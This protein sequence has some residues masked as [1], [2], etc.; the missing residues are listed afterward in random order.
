MADSLGIVALIGVLLVGT[1]VVAAMSPLTAR[2]AARNLGRR[3]TRSAIVTLGLLVGTAIISSS[4]VVGDTLNYVFLE[5]AYRRLGFVD[6]TA[7]DS[8]EGTLI[9]FNE[10][11]FPLFRDGLRDRGSPVDGVAP[12]LDLVMPVRNERGN[13]GNQQ[14]TVLGLDDA[15]ESGFG[16]LVNRSGTPVRLR[17]LPPGSAVLNERASGVLNATYGH[18]LTLF[19]GTTNQTVVFAN[20][21][22]VV[23]DEGTANW[24]QRPTVLL[25][26]AAMQAAFGFSGRINLLRISNLGDVVSGVAYSERV[27]LDARLV[28]AE[29]RWRLTVATAK[30]DA[31][32]SA[33][34]IGRAASELFLVMGAF[35]VLAGILLIVNIFVMLAEERK[36]EM[37][38]SRAIGLTR[39]RLTHSFLLEG[40]AYAFAAAAIGSLAGLALGAVMIYFFDVLVPHPGVAITF[41]FDPRSVLIAFAAGI[42]LTLASIGVASARVGRLNIVR[43]IRD[44]PEPPAHTEPTRWTAT[45]I[46]FVVAGVGL[47]V[48]GA[49]V[50]TGYGLIPGLPIAAYGAAFLAAARGRARSGFTA[51]SAAVLVWILGPWRLANE[52]TDNLSALFV[53]TGAVLVLA[54]ILIAVL[55][56][57]PVLR[58]AIYRLS[59]TRSRP[60]A[61]TAVSY[62]MERKFRTGMTLAMFSLIMFMVTVIAMV[63]GL[64]ASSLDRFVREQSG[65]YDIIGYTVNYGE[66]PEFR[67]RLAQNLSLAY[68]RGGLNGT[69]SAT[70]LPGEVL[71][72]GEGRMYN[73]TIWGIDN[74]LVESNQFGFYSHLPYVLGI[75]GVRHDLADRADVWR[76]LRW[77]TSYAVVDR[78]GAGPTQF[79]PGGNRLV[80]QPGDRVVVRDPTG[81]AV[82]LTILG[83]LEQALAFTSGLFADQAMVKATFNTSL[84][85]TAY[86]FQLAPGVDPHAVRAE[87]ERVFFRYGLQTIDIREEIGTQFNASQQVLTLMQAYLGIGLL[88]GIAG[89]AVVTLRSVAER[90][91]QIGALRAIGFTRD[92]VLRTF[93][94]EIVFIAFLGI[95]IGAA[96]GVVLSWKIY[97]V[98]FADVAVFSIPWATLALNLALAFA[99]TV[100]SV[101]Q[102]AVRASR[103]PPAE[104]LR[105]IE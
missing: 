15:H 24:Q 69:S 99:A 51:S 18:R 14:I 4:L 94:L 47:L 97:L 43:A 84:A 29:H 8:F 23:R 44:L 70:V 78:S 22:D 71:R 85:Y 6:E 2:L 7:A 87:L 95:V 1:A 28:I 27:A 68:F 9:A 31:V 91:Q 61:R 39:L 72:V 105:Y 16:P 60:I 37:G 19:W 38:V 12:T 40:A 34:D 64:Q 83:I 26:L 30:A 90:R 102:P 104:A 80:V 13:K 55:N 65:G 42:A 67:S 66:I 74:F 49:S 79:V 48:W 81:R 50:P 57:A 86:F 77:N 96:L 3:R 98:Y 52:R 33:A 25:P 62:P 32:A 11:W 58:A 21:A 56:S 54:A 82:T 92:M 103:V 10:S 17:D 41:T 76:A 101:A 93:L 63:Q 36:A 73:Y 20:V 35:S 100:A 88:V 59:R 89:L 46:A 45:G 5:D 53:M 75:D